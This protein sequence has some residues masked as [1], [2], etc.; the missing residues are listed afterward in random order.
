MTRPALSI[1]PARAFSRS[2]NAARVPACPVAPTLTASVTRIELARIAQLST[3]AVP[4]R[5]VAC[6]IGDRR[7]KRVV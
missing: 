1:R 2:S 3:I 6:V 7:T 4:P 5:A